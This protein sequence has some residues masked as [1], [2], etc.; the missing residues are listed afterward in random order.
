VVAP[1]HSAPPA[2][3]AMLS[4]LAQMAGVPAVRGVIS[5]DDLHLHEVLCLIETN[6]SERHAEKTRGDLGVRVSTCFKRGLFG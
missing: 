5:S 1:A 3:V 4:P 2:P 6:H